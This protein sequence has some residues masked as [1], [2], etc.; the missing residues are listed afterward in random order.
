[1]RLHMGLEREP[2]DTKIVMESILGK[3]LNPGDNGNDGK[4]MD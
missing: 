2:R 4:L 3:C 1:M